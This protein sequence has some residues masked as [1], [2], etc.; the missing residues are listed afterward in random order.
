MTP[1]MAPRGPAEGAD[2]GRPGG[3]AGKR[4]RR[5]ALWPGRT[6][7][8]C[9]QK[10]EMPAWTNGFFSAAQTS[11]IRYLAAKLSVQSRMMS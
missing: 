6:V 7:R 4:Q 5:Q 10:A 11:L 1:G 3:G 2:S 9:P 8:S